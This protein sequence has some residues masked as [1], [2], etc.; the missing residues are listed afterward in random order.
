MWDEAYDFCVLRKGHLPTETEWEYAARGPDELIFPWGNDWN[1]RNAI[2]SGNNV[3]Q[4]SNVGSVP[5]GASWVG[6]LDMSGNVWE[7]TDS[8][9]I[10]KLL[11]ELTDT[12]ILD[13][14]EK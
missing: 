11:R 10:V 1:P 6:V 8:S 12:E 14:F 7:W 2:W 13:I 3:S 5:A 4:T 9:D